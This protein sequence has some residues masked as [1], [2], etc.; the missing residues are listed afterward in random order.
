LPPYYIIP[1]K[2]IAFSD[3]SRDAL[4]MR[5]KIGEKR[6]KVSHLALLGSVK[7]RGE[8]GIF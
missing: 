7:K 2:K 3:A 6:Q 8:K 5:K 4:E 1:Q